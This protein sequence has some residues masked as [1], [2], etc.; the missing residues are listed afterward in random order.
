MMQLLQISKEDDAFDFYIHC[1][2]FCHFL[3]RHFMMCFFLACI[4]KNVHCI[5][6]EKSKV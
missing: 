4:Y 3:L 5:L 2:I 6:Y 1:Y